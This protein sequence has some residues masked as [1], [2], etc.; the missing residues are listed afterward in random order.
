MKTSM[1]DLKNMLNLSNSRLDIV[2][3][4]FSELR[5]QKKVFIV[6]TREEKYGSKKHE[7]YLISWLGKAQDGLN[8]R[9]IRVSEGKSREQ[10]NIGKMMSSKKI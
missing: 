10:K 1:Y 8:H 2:E 9:I 4:N 3:E 5:Y 6:K 7:I